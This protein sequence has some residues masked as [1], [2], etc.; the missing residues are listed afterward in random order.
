MGYSISWLAVK[1]K[2]PA[3]IHQ[4]FDISSTKEYGDYARYPIVGRVLPSGWYLLVA[5]RCDHKIISEAVLAKNSIDCAIVA[6]SIE[7]HVMFFSAAYWEDG[8]NTWCITHNSDKDI[9]DLMVEGQPPDIFN[10]IKETYLAKQ[11]AEDNHEDDYNVDYICEIPMELART[12][13]GFKH[14]EVT[15]D[16]EKGSFEI[17]RF[18]NRRDSANAKKPWWCFWS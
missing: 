17:F 3:A 2:E 12:I 8:Q 13:V 4:Q 14:D 6:C 9:M 16:V 10:E 15:P 18:N 7:E 5:S 11:A 1:G